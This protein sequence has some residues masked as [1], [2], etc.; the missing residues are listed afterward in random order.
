MIFLSLPIVPMAQPI[1][2]D[3]A[4]GAAYR[5]RLCRWRSLSLSIVPMAQPMIFLS[6]PIAQPNDISI[7]ADCAD[8]AAYRCRLC[9]WRS[10]SLPIV[11]M[12]QP[13][14]FLSLPIAQPN[15]SSPIAAFCALL[16]RV[17]A[18]PTGLIT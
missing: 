10:L 8:G 14:I 6:L 1:A 16:L 18:A 11:P 3:C 5:C 15:D 2:A 13:M 7:A 9:R 4:D 17:Q 12:A